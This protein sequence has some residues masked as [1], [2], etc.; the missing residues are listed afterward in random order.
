[1][2]TK[3]AR[4]LRKTDLSEDTRDFA[5]EILDGRFSGLEPGAHV[6][7]HLGADLVRQ[8]SIWSWSQDGRQINVAVKREDAGRGGSRAMHEL[9][10]GA[11]VEIGGPRNHFKLQPGEC[12][13]TLIAG[14][15]GATP[16]VG[17]A[18]ELVNSRR[19]FQIYYLA[20]SRH[21]AAM[22]KAFRAL[23]LGDRYHLHCD[24]TDGQL[25][26]ASVLQSM[27]IGSDVYACGPEPMLNAVLDAGNAMRGGTIHFE[28][29]AAAADADL[30]AKDSFEIEIQSTGQILP[31]QSDESILDVL[32]A[33]GIPVDFGCSEGLCGSCIVDVID[34]EVDHRD[35]I[36]TP[37]EQATNS[38][39]CTCVSRA[40]SARLVLNL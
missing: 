29:F 20:R 27:P 22:D 25:D 21:L 15:I 30:G 7:I 12:Y 9:E 32:K 35:G 24:D 23:G 38:Y 36:L 31:V 11:T 19:E 37:D 8:Y 18:R 39:M 17:M 16:L 4:L 34:G 33:N 40:K 6:D 10:T 13:V 3:T 5:F 14:G 26:L 2:D 1:M 28:R